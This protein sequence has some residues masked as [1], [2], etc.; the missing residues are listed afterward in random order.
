MPKEKQPVRLFPYTKVDGTEGQTTLS[1]GQQMSVVNGLIRGESQIKMA[2]EIEVDLSDL[3]MYILQS[4]AVEQAAREHDDLLTETYHYMRR[5]QFAVAE[6][7]IEK[8]SR[9]SANL[10]K[11]MGDVIAE[12]DLKKT[13]VTPTGMSKLLREY[14]E[15]EKMWLKLGGIDLDVSRSDVRVT[16][17]EQQLP[18]I[19][20]DSLVDQGLST[21]EIEEF[22]SVVERSQRAITG[23]T[24]GEEDG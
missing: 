1:P 11:L 8:W 7:R 22:I 20:V 18:P 13:P 19:T 17:T 10:L 2:E 5:N 4:D 16:K 14:R 6:Q 24:A 15:L 3:R 21:R 9:L 12:W 23:P